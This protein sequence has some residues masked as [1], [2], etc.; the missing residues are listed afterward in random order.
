LLTVLLVIY[1]MGKFKQLKKKFYTL[2]KESRVHV[3]VR[4]NDM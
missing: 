2:K 3:L 1:F 4:T